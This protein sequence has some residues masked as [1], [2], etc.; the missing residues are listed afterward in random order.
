M[1]RLCV[2]CLAFILSAQIINSQSKAEKK[3][4][5][6]VNELKEYKHIQTLIDS[7]SFE[8][9]ADWATTQKGRRINLIGNSNYFRI[10]GTKTE[11]DLPYYGVAQS[12]SYGGDAGINFDCD[13]SNYEVSKVD[14][15]KKIIIKGNASDGSEKFGL[16]LTVYH[17]GNASLY[18]NSSS[19][20]GITY[21]G[22]LKEK[23]NKKE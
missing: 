4:E 10:E 1:K 2:I 18:I 11:A 7:K 19:R 16:T 12:I 14:K 9:V 6:E 22:K 15:K 5:K 23:T 3:A 8:F 17:N 20:N 21:D 13:F